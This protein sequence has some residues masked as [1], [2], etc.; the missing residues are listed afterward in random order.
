M[1]ETK[2]T[3]SMLAIGE[4]ETDETVRELLDILLLT[5]SNPSAQQS[6]V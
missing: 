3:N 4:K 1:K 5:K 2:L 6:F